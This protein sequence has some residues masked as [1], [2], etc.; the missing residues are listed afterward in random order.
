MMN[1]L[2][3]GMRGMEKESKIDPRESKA[4]YDCHTFQIAFSVFTAPLIERHKGIAYLANS[5]S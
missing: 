1:W 4:G 3:L 2:G 5:R